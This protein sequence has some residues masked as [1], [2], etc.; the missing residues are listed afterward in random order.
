MG[1]RVRRNLGTGSAEKF[2]RPLDGLL[3]EAALPDV[4]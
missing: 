3:R 4:Q 1:K 2:E